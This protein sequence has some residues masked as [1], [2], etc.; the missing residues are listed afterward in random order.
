[1]PFTFEGEGTR[2][3][4]SIPNVHDVEIEGIV[5]PGHD[6]VV[7]IDNV[8]HPMGNRIPVARGIKR[9]FNDFGFSWDNAGKN[10]HYAGSSGRAELPPS[11]RRAPSRVLRRTEAILAHTA[12]SRREP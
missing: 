11:R 3:S 5:I 2:W 10:G 4:A 6:E 1:V 7:T 12:A 8:T 9:T